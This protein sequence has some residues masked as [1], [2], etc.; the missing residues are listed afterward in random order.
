VDTI[1][2]ASDTASI[3][4]EVESV[5]KGPD[6][7]VIF[8]TSGRDVLSIVSEQE[9]DLVIADLQIGSMGGV[10]VCLE[11]RLQASYDAIDEVPVLLLL[12]RRPDIFQA[13]RSGA[14]GWIVKPL[15]A[16]RIRAGARA[17]L[18]DQ[19]YED[20]SYQPVPVLVTDDSP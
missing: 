16:L 8:A 9:V 5:L 11:M 13:R 14:E 12:D 1:L 2:V 18:N 17:L 19:R 3:R 6:T 10:A 15:D 4:R 20:T 7:E